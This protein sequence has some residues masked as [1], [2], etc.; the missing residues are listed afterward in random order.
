MRSL[1]YL[2]GTTS[3]ILGQIGVVSDNTTLALSKITSMQASVNILNDN[4]TALVD[5]TTGQS[6]GAGLTTFQNTV[7]VIGSLKQ[8]ST[9]FNCG[10]YTAPSC[11]TSVSYNFGSDYGIYMVSFSVNKDRAWTLSSY[12]H[13]LRSVNGGSFTIVLFQGSNDVNQS[14]DT[15]T[16]VRTINCSIGVGSMQILKICSY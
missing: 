11:S 7:N 6:T 4:V 14:I 10:Y 16:N 2:S 5:R 12:V 3:N 13:V 8:N 1:G 15:G 9:G